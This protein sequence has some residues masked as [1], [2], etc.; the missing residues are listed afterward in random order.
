MKNSNY[1]SWVIR[2]VFKTETICKIGLLVFFTS[3]LFSCG[4]PS[5]TYTVEERGLSESV[6]ASGEIYPQTYFFLKSNVATCVLDM[7]VKEDELVSKGDLIAVL[8]TEEEN[9][10]A[11]IAQKQISIAEENLLDSSPILRGLSV[12]IGLAKQQLDANQKNAEKYKELSLNHAVSRKDAEE[13][14]MQY[15]SSYT[16]YLSL[17]EQYKAARTELQNKAFESEKQFLQSRQVIKSPIVGKVYA[18][19][20]R[21]GES[22]NP[23]DIILLIGSDNSFKLELLVDERDIQRIIKGQTVYF[24]TD[25]YPD[26]QFVATISLI[27]PVLQKSSRCFKVEASIKDT[28]R[29]YPQ[30]SVEANIVISQ[31]KKAVFIPSAYVLKGDSVVI[32]SNGKDRKQK[33]RITSRIDGWVEVKSGLKEKD[34]I[35]KSD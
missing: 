17:Q 14:A 21:I 30:S 11:Q 8:G 7:F 23:G 33:V 4:S 9:I 27:N 29:F 10:Q 19:E 31:S 6:Y 20:K 22:P 26:R 2:I 1:F 32:R 18:I 24:E 35:V 25:T 16:R 13:A 28:I 15:E 34:I 3:M 5:E 12:Q